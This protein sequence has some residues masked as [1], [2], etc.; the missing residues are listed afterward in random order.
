ML[1]VEKATALSEL[2]KRVRLFGRPGKTTR[3]FWCACAAIN[4]AQNQM[5]DAV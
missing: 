4:G 2:W 3:C 1:G 5:V